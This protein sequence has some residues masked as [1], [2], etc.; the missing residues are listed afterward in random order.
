MKSQGLDIDPRRQG[1]EYKKEIQKILSNV[2]D[3]ITDNKKQY[4]LLYDLIVNR[5]IAI[6]RIERCDTLTSLK[7]ECNPMCIY[8]ENHITHY[9]VILRNPETERY[10]ITSSWGSG[11]VKI[12]PFIT[13]IINEDYEELSSLLYKESENEPRLTELVKK[14]F[15]AEEHGMTVYPRYVNE[16]LVNNSNSNSNS[17]FELNNSN[18]SNSN[19][20]SNHSNHSN[21][22]HSNSNIEKSFLFY[23]SNNGIR[24]ELPGLIDKKYKIGTINGFVKA[25]KSFIKQYVKKMKTHSRRRSFRNTSSRERSSVSR[26]PIKNVTRRPSRSK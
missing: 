15:L 1:L 23:K 26:S 19:S 24:L 20:N 16:T 25:M 12:K 6:R 4:V 5:R 18:H 17:N 9:F 3:I 11:Y 10:Y 22:N 21:S 13:E 2:F 7:D 14:Y 8:N